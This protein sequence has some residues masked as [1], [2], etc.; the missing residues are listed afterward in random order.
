MD[1][2]IPNRKGDKEIQVNKDEDNIKAGNYKIVNNEDNIKIF[3]R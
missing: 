3:K 2:Y 1:A